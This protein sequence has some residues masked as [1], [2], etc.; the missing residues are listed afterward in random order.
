MGQPGH[1]FFFVGI[2]AGRVPE[3]DFVVAVVVPAAFYLGGSDLAFYENQIF[4][5]IYHG[6]V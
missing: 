3:H 2:C 6:F 4:R 5:G 1:I